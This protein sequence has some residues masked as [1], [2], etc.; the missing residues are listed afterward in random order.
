MNQLE[1]APIYAQSLFLRKLA[2]TDTEKLYQMSVEPGMK[3][4]IP[5]QVY[6]DCNHARQ[7]LEFLMAQYRPDANPKKDPIVLGV[8]LKNTQELIGHVGLSPLEKHVEIGYAI[9]EKHQKKG[10]ASEAIL[11]ISDWA[12]K[13]FDLPL[14]LGVVASA[15]KASCRTLEKAGFTFSQEEERLMHG[16][17][18]GVRIYFCKPSE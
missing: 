15:N 13:Y 17:M 12:F 8:C 1:L 9:E 3:Q 11:A 4:W 18:T 16:E 2:L 10:Y 6:A 5:D 14:I 7:V